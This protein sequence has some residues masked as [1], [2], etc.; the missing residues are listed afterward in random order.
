MWYNINVDYPYLYRE[1]TKTGK[2]QTIYSFNFLNKKIELFNFKPFKDKE[3]TSKAIFANN[4][5]PITLKKEYQEEAIIKEEIC[6][7]EECIDKATL[8]GLEKIKSNLKEEEKIINY[9]VIKVLEN[10]DKISLNLFVTV[11]EDI[12]SYSL[13]EEKIEE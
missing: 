5:V 1:T 9:K 8:L 11:Y 4:Y 3:V 2:K 10:E 6:T 7:L 12:T 13:I